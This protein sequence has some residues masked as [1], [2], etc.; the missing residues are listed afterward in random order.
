MILHR[1]VA[2]RDVR[3]F[4]HAVTG[5][6]N[7]PVFVWHDDRAL[8]MDLDAETAG[9]YLNTITRRLGSRQAGNAVRAPL[10]DHEPRRELPGCYGVMP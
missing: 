1:T 9:R 4:L 7:S 8:A 2:G 3:Q 5:P 10:L 6:R